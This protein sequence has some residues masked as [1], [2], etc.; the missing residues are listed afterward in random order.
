M[1]VEICSCLR[2]WQNFNESASQPQRH[3]QEMTPRNNMKVY[4]SA[5]SVLD[6]YLTTRSSISYRNGLWK[7]STWHR[8]L[9]IPS[10]IR[11]WVLPT[12]NQKCLLQLFLI[13]R[14]PPTS[15]LIPP[16]TM[17]SIKKAT[18]HNSW[19][20]H[21]GVVESSPLDR[22]QISD[23]L[24]D[25]SVPEPWMLTRFSRR[26]QRWA[27][28]VDVFH[29]NIIVTHGWINVAHQPVRQSVSHHTTAPHPPRASNNN[30]NNYK[31]TSSKG[32]VRR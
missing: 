24:F 25:I 14:P 26:D 32:S 1:T 13:R 21:Q 12:E 18:R 20:H 29:W 9:L 2:F 4:V 6:L 15:H 17:M 8:F 31:T 19:D 10:Y 28:D 27:T 7:T 3:S 5:L 11:I 16:R 23:L 22:G 30:N